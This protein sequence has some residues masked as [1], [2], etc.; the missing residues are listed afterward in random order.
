M[1][2]SGILMLIA[3]HPNKAEL[4]WGKIISQHVESQLTVFSLEG[5]LEFRYA[6]ERVIMT[7]ALLKR[8]CWL[9]LQLPPNPANNLH[10]HD[11][12]KQATFNKIGPRC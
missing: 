6:D 8:N 12:L 10:L 1:S 5:L 3:P 2:K 11:F 7:T 9:I 4:I